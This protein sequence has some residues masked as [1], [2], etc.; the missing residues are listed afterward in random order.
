[1]SETGDLRRA[2]ESAC[3][4]LL[5]CCALAMPAAASTRIDLNRDW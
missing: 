1:M 4:C 5:L 2:I 3:L